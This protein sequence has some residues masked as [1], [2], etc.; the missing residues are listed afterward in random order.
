[1]LQRFEITN[2]YQTSLQLICNEIWYDFDRASSL[3]CGNKMPTRCNR[4]YLLQILLFAEHVSRHHYAHHQELDSI[5]Q[6]VAACGLWC[7][8]PH[9]TDNLKTKAPNTTGSNHLYNN[10]E[11]LMMGIM[12]PETRW[13]SNK[14][15][16][17]KH[18]LHLVGIYFHMSEILTSKIRCRRISTA[19]CSLSYFVKYY[20]YLD[21]EIRNPKHISSYGNL[22]FL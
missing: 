22:F 12:V 11:L 13:A 21:F 20:P 2:L 4:W 5:I 17:K 18:L 15:C 8:A 7:S 1:M 9:H 6:K 14:I 10:L 19:V 3:I 16:N